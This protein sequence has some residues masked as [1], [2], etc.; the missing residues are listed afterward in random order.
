MTDMKSQVMVGIIRSNLAA[1]KAGINQAC[2][3]TTPPRQP[4]QIALV[5]VSKR[6]PATAVEQAYSCGLRDFGENYV[7][8]AVNKAQELD[9]CPDCHWH[10]IGAL[11]SNKTTVAA[12]Q[13]SWV[14]TLE[15]S[16]TAHR[17]GAARCET[18]LA[19]IQ[20]CVQVNLAN[21]ASKSGL[22]PTEVADFLTACRDITG[23]KLRGLMCIPEP[24]LDRNERLARFGELAAL[25]HDC[26]TT[27]PELDTLSMGM[28]ADYPDAIEAGATVVR[29][30]TVL[31]GART[32]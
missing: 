24:G 20:A 27:M 15:R 5:A 11:Q 4:D 26:Q 1:V 16:K 19:P 31:F 14:H 9:S 25:L 7:Q 2:S 13:F 18:G 23:I 32:T 6:Q 8:E 21:E 30:G 10:L 17:L 29:L 3:A 28:S 12:Q 22:Q